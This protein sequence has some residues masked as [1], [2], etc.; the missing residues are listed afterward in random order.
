MASDEPLKTA[1]TWHLHTNVGKKS[2]L[3]CK[4]SV[5]K[6]AV[7]NGTCLLVWRNYQLHSPQDLALLTGHIQ[8]TLQN[9]LAPKACI[10]QVSWANSAHAR[11]EVKGDWKWITS[12]VWWLIMAFPWHQVL[13]YPG[14][15]LLIF[16]TLWLMLEN[17]P[18][19]EAIKWFPERKGGYWGL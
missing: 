9:P 7:A 2:H 3:F 11:A 8:K 17:F 12:L 1:R 6:T 4:T 5:P 13:S 16:Y 14:S 15:A 10:S 19:R 18:T